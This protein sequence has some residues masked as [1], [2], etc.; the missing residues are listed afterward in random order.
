MAKK[1]KPK[2]PAVPAPAAETRRQKI[3]RLLEKYTL[4]FEELRSELGQSRKA[5]EEELGHLEKTVKRRGSKLVVG[6][7]LCLACGYEF[8]AR[9]ARRFHAP[10]RCPACK[11][12]RVAPPT[13]HISPDDLI[14]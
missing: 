1:Q 11:E 9:D 2:S 12:E 10:K 7:A 14:G 13:F 4:D 5:L 3:I 8:E 6:P